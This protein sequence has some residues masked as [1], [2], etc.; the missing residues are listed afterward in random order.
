M[1]LLS[2]CRSIYK[3]VVPE[4][5]NEGIVKA[6][7]EKSKAEDTNSRKAVRGHT[8]HMPH[9]LQYHVLIACV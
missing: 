5:D 7:S 4:V 8:K 3:L 2:H 1:C 9:V 6:L